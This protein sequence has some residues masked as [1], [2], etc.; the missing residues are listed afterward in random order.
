M[1]SGDTIGGAI[2]GVFARLQGAPLY[3]GHGTDNAWDEAVQLVLHIAG[4]P[5]DSDDSVVSLPLDPGLAPALEEALRR[6]IDE[7]EPLP[8]ITG[9][10]FFAGQQF[11]ADRRAL[12]PRS[13]LGALILD[14]YAPWWTAPGGPRL[15]DL[16]CGGGCIGLAAALARP[17]ATVILADID[18]EA[19]S[20]AAENIA[21]HGMLDRAETVRSDLFGALAGERFDLIL[22]NPPYVDAADIA[23]MP[24]E[25]HAEPLG[26]LAAGDDGLDLALEI[27]A[28]APEH[29]RAGGGMFLELGNSWAALDALCPRQALTWLEFADGGHGVLFAT[30]DELGDWQGHFRELAA[31]RAARGV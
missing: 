16:C 21:L 9:R 5:A 31:R 26:A 13:P 17:D 8:Y 18:S 29:L 4:L 3:F 1:S 2:E 27:L 30:R 7:R 20:L 19:L 25:F 14:D 28:S 6:R 12:V 15:L 23:A 10:A 22:C 11:L 24:E